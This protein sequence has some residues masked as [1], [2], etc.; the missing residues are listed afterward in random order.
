MPENTT[1]ILKPEITSLYKFKS[2]DEKGYYKDILNN[3]LYFPSPKELN[4]PFDSKIN[5]RYDLCSEEELYD[6]GLKTNPHLPIKQRSE[7]AR[8]KAKEIKNQSTEERDKQNKELSENRNSKAG[9]FSLTAENYCNLLMWSHY[10]DSHKGFCLEFDVQSIREFIIKYFIEYYFPLVFN[11]VKYSDE[12]PKIIPGTDNYAKRM[13]DALFTKS[14]YW[15]HE[16]E[17]RIIFWNIERRE[18]EIPC[19]IIKSIYFGLS[20]DETKIK[21]AIAIL[22]ESN[23]NIGLYKAKKRKNEF[24]L[25]FEKLE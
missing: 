2:F 12:M 3:K 24:G 10:A 18:I 22:E 8:T 11:I 4:D 20:A 25:E 14:K 5:I 19:E 7:W 23:P 16:N 9:V 17:W 13:D 1:S 15:K 6:I 21:K